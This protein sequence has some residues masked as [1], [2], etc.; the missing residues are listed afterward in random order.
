VENKYL[1][2]GARKIKLKR[3]LPYKAVEDD[4][5]REEQH[6]TNGEAIVKFPEKKR[7]VVFQTCLGNR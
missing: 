1:F 2:Y 7:P 4:I 6:R 3:F 5:I